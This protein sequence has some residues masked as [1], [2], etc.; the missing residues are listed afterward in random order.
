MSLK[1]KQRKTEMAF[2]IEEAYSHSVVRSSLNRRFI[3]RIFPKNLRNTAML[4]MNALFWLQVWY[5]LP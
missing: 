3:F 5:N 1:H 4:R 2:K